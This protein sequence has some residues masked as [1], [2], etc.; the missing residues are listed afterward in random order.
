MKTNLKTKSKKTI[1]P[2]SH[3]DTK[4]DF[5]LSSSFK[6]LCDLVPWCHYFPTALLLLALPAVSGCTPD[7]SETTTRGRLEV[8]IAES[9]APPMVEQVEQFVNIY[10]K[11]GAQL[12]YSLMSSD[13]A[14]KHLIS[15]TARF[16]VTTRPLT[17]AERE[18]V[19]VI[20]DYNLNGILVAYDGIAVIVHHKNPMEE[21]STSEMTKVLS[22]EITRWEQFSR[23]KGMKGIIDLLYQDSSDV[24]SFVAGRLLH[25]KPVRKDVRRTRSSLETLRSLVERPL[26]LGLVGTSW[27]DSAR[28]PAKSL[29]VAETR[30][31][32]DTTF[33]VA[34]EAF[35]KY[36]STHPAHIYRS[37]YPLK[38]A[39]Y[40]Y[41]YGP[42]GSIASGFGT[43][44]ANKDGQRLFLA[45]NV[46]P[47][48][49][50]IR[51]KAPQ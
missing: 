2:Q 25:G 21:I 37:Y 3:E 1:P 39:I 41:S 40:I 19:P 5:G 48:T 44:V 51:L 20:Q 33:R 30:Q 24:S 31:T 12:S 23:A 9:I 17:A 8:L 26:S 42:V 16:I 28:V 6:S 38:R 22:G 13:D 36:Y 27:I 43:F 14:I 7:K 10:S 46:V 15:D 29:K 45:R 4:K 35:G 50:P 47:A 11:N 18:R 34:P 32:T 49:Q